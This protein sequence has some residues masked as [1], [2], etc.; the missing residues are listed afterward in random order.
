MAF[1]NK[2]KSEEATSY[3]TGQ[4]FQQHREKINSI[5]EK[6]PSAQSPKGWKRKSTF[7]IGGLEYFGFAETSDILVVL[8]TQGRGLIDMAKDE[9]IARDNITDYPLDRMLLTGEGFDILE[10]KIIK[11]ASKYGGSLLPVSNQSLETLVRVSPLYPCEDIIFQPPYENCFADG[12]SK[13]THSDNCVRVYRGFLYCYGFSF[14][15]KYFV[16]ADEGG[17]TYWEADHSK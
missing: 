16:I 17:V 9:K 5:L 6:I 11:L 2:N 3:W 10:G 13:N 14:S 15:G 12:R 4:D 7:A 8:S 1:W